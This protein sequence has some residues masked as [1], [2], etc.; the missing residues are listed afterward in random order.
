[1][2]CFSLCV[3]SSIFLWIC[4]F[5]L[6][7]CGR[8]L[9]VCFSVSLSLCDFARTLVSYLS[10][11]NKRLS[12]LLLSF[13]SGCVSCNFT[14]RQMKHP[15]LLTVISRPACWFCPPWPRIF[16]NTSN[17]MTAFM[18]LHVISAFNS[19]KVSELMSERFVLAAVNEH[20][21]RNCK[22]WKLSKWLSLM[23]SIEQKC[24]FP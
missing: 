11:T 24:F 16:H 7:V 17:H 22:N 13:S 23:F 20:A 5:S 9:S 2:A 15:P 19:R 4:V 3:R 12:C 1:M 18:F 21:Q 10:S 6:W 8:S 14:L